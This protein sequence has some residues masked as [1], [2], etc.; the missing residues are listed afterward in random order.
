MIKNSEIP[1]SILCI[2]AYYFTNFFFQCIVFY[3]NLNIVIITNE[4][5]NLTLSIIKLN[6]R[7]HFLYLGLSL[8]INDLLII[9]HI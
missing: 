5:A 3:L 4:I 1:K 6:I 8:F 7:V 2:L 9:L